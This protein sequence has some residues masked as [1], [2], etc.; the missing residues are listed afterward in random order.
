MSEA[1]GGQSAMLMIDVDMFKSMDEFVVLL[2]NTTERAA[3]DVAERV[4]EA[5][6]NGAGG[7]AATVS[8]GSAPFSSSIRLTIQS[9]DRALYVAR[10]RGAIASRAVPSE[11]W[12]ACN[13]ESALTTDAAQ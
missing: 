9:A 2:P 8:I 6:E 12:L 13:R 1:V 3:I 5:V 11:Q 10:S 7:S 4:R